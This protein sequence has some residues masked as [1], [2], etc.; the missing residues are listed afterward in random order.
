MKLVTSSWLWSAKTRPWRRSTGPWAPSV[1]WGSPLRHRRSLAPWQLALTRRTMLWR[2]YEPCRPR[3][4]EL[5]QN[6][7]E[8]L[9]SL[10]SITL[11]LQTASRLSQQAE[12]GGILE[13]IEVS[14][15]LGGAVIFI[16]R[17]KKI[18]FFSLFFRISQLAWMILA[19]FISSL[20]KGWRRPPCLWR[21]RMLCQITWTLNLPLRRY[22]RRSFINLSFF[23]FLL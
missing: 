2:E 23:E 21:Q 12:L 5:F 18:N 10:D 17:A 9:F 7:Y 19:V 4:L 16:I 13:E 3:G 6:L 1:L 20:K 8:T 11:A 22:E 14:C 15:P